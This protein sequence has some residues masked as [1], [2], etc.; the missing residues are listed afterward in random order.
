MDYPANTTVLA[1]VLCMMR[2]NAD[3]LRALE[4]TEAMLPYMKCDAALKAAFAE[5]VTTAL[6]SV[7]LARDAAGGSDL[8]P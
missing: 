1:R 6:A 5:Q 8:P 7:R 3:A 4:A 2:A